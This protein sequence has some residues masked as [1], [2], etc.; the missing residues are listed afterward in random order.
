MK[1]KEISRKII[2]G[3]LV[4]AI[5]LLPTMVFAGEFEDDELETKQENQIQE[6]VKEE[7]KSEVKTENK[8]EGKEEIIDKGEFEDDELDEGDKEKEEPKKEDVQ[9]ITDAK[10]IKLLDKIK[11]TGKLYKTIKCSAEKGTYT[12]QVAVVTEISQR[13]EGILGV[14]FTR[15]GKIL[16]TFGYIKVAESK[17]LANGKLLTLNFK[18]FE[19]ESGSVK[20]NGKEYDINSHTVVQL[21]N[22]GIQIDDEFIA[23]K[24]GDEIEIVG[25]KGNFCLENESNKMIDRFI[26]NGD[27][28][29][30]I[31]SNGFIV[32]GNAIV[33][34]EEVSGELEVTYEEGDVKLKIIS[35]E[36]DGKEVKTENFKTII[37]DIISKIIGFIKDIFSKIFGKLF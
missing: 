29:F 5:M 1:I 20:V 18:L 24:E 2:S 11:F 22:G 7:N 35:A 36:I 16:S 33:N 26:I 21:A 17:V 34:G 15:D 25:L 31:T 10:Q 4:L 3:F 13:D 27:T 28:K 12:E 19:G 9:Y 14:T 6:V 23:L 30:K 32:K 37:G 8:S